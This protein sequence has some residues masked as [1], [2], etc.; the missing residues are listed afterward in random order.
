MTLFNI[1]NHRVNLPDHRDRTLDLPTDTEVQSVPDSF[2][3]W[4]HYEEVPRWDQGQEGSCG[5]HALARAIQHEEQKLG[6]GF[7]S[8]DGGRVSPAY[9]YYSA[10][11]LMNTETQDSGVDNRSLFQGL[12]EF[13]WVHEKDMPYVA[14]DFATPPSKDAMSDGESHGGSTYAL[15]TPGHNSM[16][17]A[18]AA[19]KA[20]VIGFAVPDYFEDASRWDPTKAYLPLPTAKGVDFQGFIGGHDVAVTGYDYT[21]TEFNVPVFLIDN[22]WG[23]SWGA[24]F[25]APSKKAGRFAIDAQWFTTSVQGTKLV[26][27]L[28]VITNER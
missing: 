5:G 28:T 14:G 23:D 15:V 22:S 24:S 12:K 19:G 7:A 10:R 6:T 21:C 20:I 4:A 25:D 1:Y 8:S 18:I 9:A 11:E 2:D 26:F 13:G 16:R 27:D 17:T 3:L